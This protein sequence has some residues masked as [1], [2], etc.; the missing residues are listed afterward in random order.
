M[1]ILAAH[2]KSTPNRSVVPGMLQAQKM[3]EILLG[4]VEKLHK[5]G[6]LVKLALSW[7]AQ[8]EYLIMGSRDE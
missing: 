8:E 7:A 6:L 5:G 4:A 3:R 1:K 2:G